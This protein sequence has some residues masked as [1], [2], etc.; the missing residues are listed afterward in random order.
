VAETV[1][2]LPRGSDP[3]PGRSVGSLPRG[4]H[5]SSL[6]TGECTR[7]IIESCSNRIRSVRHLRHLQEP[8][9]TRSCST[10]APSRTKWTPWPINRSR[11]RV[12]DGDFV[13]RRR[14]HLGDVATPRS[15]PRVRP[16]SIAAAGPHVRGTDD[17]STD[18][19]PRRSQ[20]RAWAPLAAHSGYTR[21][22]FPD[23]PVRTLVH[24]ARP[25]LSAEISYANTTAAAVPPCVLSY[26][27]PDRRNDPFQV[28]KEHQQRPWRARALRTSLVAIAARSRGSS[29]SARSG[30][31]RRRLVGQRN[32]RLTSLPSVLV[33][34]STVDVPIGRSVEFRS[35]PGASVLLFGRRLKH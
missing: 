15:R 12:Q 2:D 29:S 22:C 24:L 8:I 35:D 17:A 7:R 16:T 5:G 28:L 31:A 18:Q 23:H 25:M 19:R 34:V 10:R 32:L 14:G 26:L 21:I 33:R 13:A 6:R 11:P 27:A 20:S 1:G 9:A 3:T 30:R 4:P